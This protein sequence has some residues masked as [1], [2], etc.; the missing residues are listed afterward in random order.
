LIFTNYG[1]LD[2][3]ID[4]VLDVDDKEQLHVVPCHEVDDEVM[5]P[6]PRS[7]LID[8]CFS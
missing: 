5:L 4:E 3:S 2:L 6:A 1:D 7:A 8:W